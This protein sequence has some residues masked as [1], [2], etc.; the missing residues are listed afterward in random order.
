M[1]RETHPLV[2]DVP[3][4][5]RSE[6]PRPRIAVETVLRG[7]GVRDARPLRVRG[8]NGRGSGILL[9][10]W[11]MKLCAGY[12]I[13]CPDGRVRHYPYHNEGDAKCDAGVCDER[14]CSP[15]SD[16]P[17]SGGHRPARAGSTL[18]GRWHSPTRNRP[19]GWRDGVGQREPGK[20]TVLAKMSRSHWTTVMWPDA[21]RPSAHTA[22]RVSV[23]ARMSA[24]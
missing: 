10:W 2:Q 23:G 19:V 8:N 14:G 5:Q 22:L 21:R 20:G 1:G 18:F 12:E 6:A 24:A 4:Q 7:S 9:R 15:Y 13:V 11:P 3:V 17:L 16:D